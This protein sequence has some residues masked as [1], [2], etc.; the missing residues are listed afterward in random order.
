LDNFGVEAK[1][2]LVESGV[3]GKEILERGVE[4]AEFIFKFLLTV[5][6][7]E[8]LIIREGDFE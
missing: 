2:L 7:N 4:E 5:E 8:V 1:E 3:A 6:F